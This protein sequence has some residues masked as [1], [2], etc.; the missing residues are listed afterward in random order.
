LDI[1]GYFAYHLFGN[2]SPHTNKGRYSGGISI[3]C[4]SHLQDKI[5]VVETHQCGIVWIK[6]CKSLFHFNIP[7]HI[8]CVYLPPQQSNILRHFNNELDIFDLI[9]TGIEKYQLQGK[10]MLTGDVNSRTSNEIDYII[11]DQ[12]LDNNSDLQQNICPSMRINMDPVLDAHG[13]RL[14]QLCKST[15]MLICNGRLCNDKHG[16]YTF[17]NNNGSS[18][19]DYCILN[20]ADFVYINDFNVQP[21]T[22]IS[23]HSALNI[24]I[25]RSKRSICESRDPCIVSE[26]YLEWDETMTNVFRAS[27]LDSSDTLLQISSDLNN[28]SINESVQQFTQYIQ[29]KAFSIFGKTR[30]TKIASDSR[31]AH[32]NKKSWFNKDCI[33]ARKQ[34]NIARN[35]YTR[36]KSQENKVTFLNKRREY[37]NI[38]RKYKRI[39]NR[40]ES[41]RINNLAKSNP[42]A[43]WKNV[44]SQYT[45]NDSNTHRVSMNDM[46]THFNNLY[47]TL[48]EHT[49][50]DNVHSDNLVYD[51]DLDTEFT[52]QEV[53][54]AVFAQN[55]MK[56][57][58]T[59]RLVAEVFKSSYDI[60]AP[61]LTKL[62]NTIFSAGIFPQSWGE[63]IIIP[64]FKGGNHEAKNFRAITLNNIISKIYSKLLV[65][66]LIRWSDK[67]DTLIDNQYGFQKS[68]STTD[69]IFILHALISKTLASKKKLF[70]GF[71]DWEKMFDK[72]DRIYLWRKLLNMN[73]SAK[74][75][76]ALKSMYTV[77]R[78]YI[79]YGSEKSEYIA[80]HIGVKQGDPASSILCL[81]FLNDILDNI[82]SNLEG[83][84]KIDDLKIFLLLFAD[85]AVVFSND[86]SSLQSILNDIEKY[87]ITWGL[88]LNTNK[89]K[90]MIF[91]NG[92]HTQHDF[93]IYNSRIEIVESFKYLGVHLFKNGNWNRTQKRV[94]QH[95]SFSLHKLFIAFNQVEFPTSRKISMFDS[96]VEPILNY[97]AEIWGYH[98][99]PDIEIILSKFYRKILCVKRSTNLNALYGELGC[100][101]M[102]IRRQ[103]LMIKY[104]IKLLTLPEDSLLYKTYQMLKTD[105]EN[106]HYYNRNNWAYQLKHILDTCGLSYIW[107]N[108]STM[109]VNYTIVK[110]RILDM[111]KQ[112]WYSGINNPGRLETYS[113]F[114]NEFIFENYLDFI[115]IRKYRIALTRFRV[116][117]HDLAIERGR[118]IN[119]PRN[120]RKC[121]YCNSNILENEYHF[122]LI[123]PR[124]SDLRSQFI[125]R[126]YY[127]WPTLQKF[128][129]LLT[130]NSK[131]TIIDLSKFI[132]FANK[133]RT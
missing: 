95:A 116:S 103:L 45:N 61:Y 43:F 98:D 90:I 52:A 55:N 122:L 3:Y 78:S 102:S 30:T 120:E 68:K 91:E 133:L 57:A 40:N 81:F 2:K 7:Y 118:Y 5:S 62:Y 82:N 15:N 28:I 105:V 10:V 121:I 92:R 115:T 56:C 84:M 110:N 29:D 73:V 83:I 9:E 129:N 112:S 35:L 6:L 32:R 70:V 85:D 69:C 127:T 114:K 44:K 27:L 76:T 42:R 21:P 75:V 71:L 17:I 89:T 63:G 132:Y 12:F 88:R 13:K 36:N 99:A 77:V 64:I 16:E 50:D 49:H 109:P 94:A 23:D 20:K 34:F 31:P 87:C 130:C 18:V 74:F 26:D 54:Q 131:K 106:R 108:Q 111:Y 11:F 101:P 96:L 67:H 117:S 47:S 59:D 97:S 1:K 48:P 104:W 79:R 24:C 124:Y 38:K 25:Q 58:G 80:S 53:R 33:D 60:I 126:Y 46:H 113:L 37:T 65:N 19:V 72:I 123:C 14:I 41:E 119:V 93:F 86:A 107:H 22:D 51:E 128:V 4:K 125:K 66:R 39:Y 8:A 100:L